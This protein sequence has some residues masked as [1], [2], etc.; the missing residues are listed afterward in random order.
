MSRGLAG[1]IVTNS[2]ISDVRG[3]TSELIYAGY[4]VE[5]LVTQESY[6]NV[7]HLL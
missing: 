5:D 6:E 4:L 3:D 7:V 2:K 1:V